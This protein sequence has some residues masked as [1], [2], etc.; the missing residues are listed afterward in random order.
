MKR[1]RRMMPC[2]ICMD[3]ANVW[4]PAF[5]LA[6]NID[7]GRPVELAP[8][9]I[10]DG[11]LLEPSAEHWLPCS[12]RVRLVTNNRGALA[13]WVEAEAFRRG[14]RASVFWS[15][16]GD[17]GQGPTTQRVRWRD[18][19]YAIMMH[20]LFDGMH[21]QESLESFARAVCAANAGR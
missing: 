7:T 13:K 15:G 5:G 11:V 3:E 12:G 4:R 14:I 21:T 20:P 16:M 8:G 2:T 6:R 18:G 9:I 10:I 19:R 17:H 1:K